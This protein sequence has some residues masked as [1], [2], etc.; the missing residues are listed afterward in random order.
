MKKVYNIEPI[1]IVFSSSPEADTFT[2]LN[3]EEFKRTKSLEFL[4]EVKP[5]EL[6]D[7]PE[8]VT[9]ALFNRNYNLD[10][11]KWEIIEKAKKK[12]KPKAKK[13]KKK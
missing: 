5:I 8:R 9:K 11:V 6:L 1:G 3:G 12:R 2:T 4:A 13:E 10:L 7:L